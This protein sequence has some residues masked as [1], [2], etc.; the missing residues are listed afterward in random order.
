MM[1]Q[2]QAE[3]TWEINIY[4]NKQLWIIHQSIPAGYYKI[5]MAIWKDQQEN[6]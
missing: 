4:G 2:S 6:M 3:S 1:A 5:N